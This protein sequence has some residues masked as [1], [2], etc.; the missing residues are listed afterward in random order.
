MTVKRVFD[1]TFALVGLIV[2]FLF[3]VLVAILI[4]IESKCQVFYRGVRVGAV[5]ES[6]SQFLSSA[7]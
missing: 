4:K 7:A 3:F 5:M 1:C 6:R 2:T